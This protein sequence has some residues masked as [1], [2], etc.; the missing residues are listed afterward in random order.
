MQAGWKSRMPRPRTL[1]GRVIPA[2]IAFASAACLLLAF[3][4]TTSETPVNKPRR[5][6]CICEDAPYAT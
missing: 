4:F 5:R 6:T 1:D 3:N 2:S